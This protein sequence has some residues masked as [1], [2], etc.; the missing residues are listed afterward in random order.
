MYFPLLLD[1]TSQIEMDYYQERIR[2]D[3]LDMEASKGFEHE[4]GG[5]FEGDHAARSDYPGTS[6]DIVT[7][8]YPADRILQ[9]RTWNPASW[10]ASST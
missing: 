6:T 10:P 3:V 8:E 5:V 7:Q 9:C 4:T 2:L 1:V